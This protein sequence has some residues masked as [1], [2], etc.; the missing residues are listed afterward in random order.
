MKHTPDSI[1]LTGKIEKEVV[2]NNISPFIGTLTVV[3]CNQI[4]EIGG[5]SYVYNTIYFNHWNTAN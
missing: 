2:K 5:I 1:L 4:K 3:Q